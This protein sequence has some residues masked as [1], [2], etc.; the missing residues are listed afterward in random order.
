ML[1]HKIHMQ[2]SNP[3]NLLNCYLYCGM[4][5][6][7]K[8]CDKSFINKSAF[9][10]FVPQLIMKI[11]C[12][13]TTRFYRFVCAIVAQAYFFHDKN[14]FYQTFHDHNTRINMNG[15]TVNIS[16]IPPECFVLNSESGFA[17]FLQQSH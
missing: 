9:L 12:T 5:F 6:I 2:I 1:N 8:Y 15:K 4:S 7:N 13:G 3:F 11:H 17:T 14:D 10:N 16:R